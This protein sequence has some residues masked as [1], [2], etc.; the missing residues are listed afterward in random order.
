MEKTEN[1]SCSSSR[2]FNAMFFHKIL[3]IG[4]LKSDIFC[5]MGDIPV[6]LH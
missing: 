6:I 5:G 4:S 1:R 3:E 2:K